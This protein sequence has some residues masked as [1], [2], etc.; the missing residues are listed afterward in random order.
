[1]LY[2]T[3]GE[4]ARPERILEA[5]RA[6]DTAE[7]RRTMEAQRRLRR[8]AAVAA[9]AGG[10]DF[11]PVL[12]RVWRSGDDSIRRGL[13]VDGIHPTAAGYELMGRQVAGLI[14]SQRGNV[15]RAS[16]R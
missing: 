11:R 12:D 5:I 4:L 2:T 13:T 8:V 6:A 7:A 16:N 10:C 3:F 15:S 9:R 1:V 14:V